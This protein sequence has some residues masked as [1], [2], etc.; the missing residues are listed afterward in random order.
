[1]AFE[2]GLE[3]KAG[4]YIGEGQSWETRKAGRCEIRDHVLHNGAW[5]IVGPIGIFSEGIKERK[6][7]K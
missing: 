1:M 6:L 2:R 4:F 7:Q 3:E 5:H